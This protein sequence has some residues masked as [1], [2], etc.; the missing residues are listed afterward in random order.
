MSTELKK[1]KIVA[2]I[3]IHGNATTACKRAGVP[4]R[5]FYMWRETDKYF[6]G[7]VQDAVERSR[8]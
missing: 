3:A 2:E 6:D 4:R 1:T 8:R 5:T 7:L